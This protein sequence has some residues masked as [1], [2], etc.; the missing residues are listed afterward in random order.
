MLGIAPNVRIVDVTHAVPPQNV[1]RILKVFS[2]E[3]VEAT[4]AIAISLEV[5]RWN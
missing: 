2:D 5:V 4:V 3:G 1:Q